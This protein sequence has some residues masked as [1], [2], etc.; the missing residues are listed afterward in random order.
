MHFTLRIL[1]KYL[2]G[3]IV[4]WYIGWICILSLKG[5]SGN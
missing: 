3:A 2:V 1:G 4:G 5:L